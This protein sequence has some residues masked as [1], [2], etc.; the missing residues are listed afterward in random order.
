M[1]QGHNNLENMVQGHNNLRFR[2][3]EDN[4]RFKFLISSNLSNSMDTH[5]HENSEKMSINR[6]YLF[7]CKPV[8]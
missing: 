1:F 5:K 7:T 8:I 4:F 3:N 2:V 6:F